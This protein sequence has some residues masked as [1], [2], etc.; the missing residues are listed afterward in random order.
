MT[1]ISVKNTNRYIR[2]DMT[3]LPQWLK[4]RHLYSKFLKRLQIYFLNQI[5]DFIML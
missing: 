3:F 4:V 2:E 5:S 1:W